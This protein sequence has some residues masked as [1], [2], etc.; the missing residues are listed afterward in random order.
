MFVSHV[1][2]VSHV[3]PY[4]VLQLHVLRLDVY[5]WMPMQ[6]IPETSSAPR[7]IHVIKPT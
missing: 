6:E 3:T 5:C 4:K 7:L 1:S 2:H